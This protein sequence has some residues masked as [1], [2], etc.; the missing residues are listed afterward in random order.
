MYYNCTVGLLHCTS[1]APL[2][3]PQAP[4]PRSQA[5]RGEYGYQTELSV[6][7]GLA[8]V[9]FCCDHSQGPTHQSPWLESLEFRLQCAW[10]V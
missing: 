5:R 7:S 1:K 2:S 6:H 3:L 4:G 9:L 8:A 10:V